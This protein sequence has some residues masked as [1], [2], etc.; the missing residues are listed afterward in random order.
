MYFFYYIPVGL[1]VAW[2]RRPFVTW[3]I[4]VSCVIL[5]L[6]YKYKPF[7]A[8]WDLSLLTFQP[9]APSLSTAITHAFLHGGWFHL[10]GNLVYMAVFGPSLEDRLG[11]MRFYA[12][13]AVS[14]VIGAYTHLVLTALYS[15]DYLAYGVIGASGA[16]SGILGAH[17][18]RLYYSRVRIAYWVFMPL[19]G[20]N[21]AGRS[22]LPAVF[23]IFLWFAL[24]GIRAVMQFGTGGMRVAY[25]VHLGGFAAGILLALAFGGLAAARAEGHLVTAR[26]R[27]QEA[28]WLGAQAE[29]GEYLARVSADPEAHAELARASLAA[30]D[31]ATARKHFADAARAA[32]ER[33]AR[34]AAETYF[35]EGM[36]HIVNF[37]LPEPL[38]LDLACGMERTL[39]H[40]AA[41][42]AYE[43]FVWLYPRSAE[44]P[45]VLLRMALINERRLGNPKEAFA[46]Y[47]RLVADYGEDRWADHARM[48]IGRLALADPELAAAGKK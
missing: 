26:R 30:G 11:P 48:E 47:E 23:A 9:S 44:A 24:Q 31:A 14:A 40:R 43:N 25:S 27:F 34:D 8:W 20:V 13:F 3:F 39:K 33:G 42:H 17:L 18:V 1:D 16:T 41:M 28:D 6:V 5:F 2:R 7:G 35:E 15:P 36:R 19:Q 32:Q 22:Y 38:H 37:A 21:R 29:Y 45:F 10:V 12:V 4:C 46:C